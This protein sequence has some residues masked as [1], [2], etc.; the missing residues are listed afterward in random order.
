MYYDYL[1]K[2]ELSTDGYVLLIITVNGTISCLQYARIMLLSS[3]VVG[4]HT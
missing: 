2:P 1:H 3:L 4:N